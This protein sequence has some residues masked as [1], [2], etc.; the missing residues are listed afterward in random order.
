M[1][2]T[3]SFDTIWALY[4]RLSQL[5]LER[6]ISVHSSRVRQYLLYSP[7]MLASHKIPNLSLQLLLFKLVWIDC[8]SRIF[9]VF[10]HFQILLMIP[11]SKCI[12]C[13]M[14]YWIWRKYS[15]HARNI[16]LI[17]TWQ[18]FFIGKLLALVKSCMCRIIFLWWL[19]NRK[20]GSLFVHEIICMDWIGVICIYLANNIEGACNKIE[21]MRK[22][23][24]ITIHIIC[25]VYTFI[26]I[27]NANTHSNLLV[28]VKHFQRDKKNN[29]AA[30]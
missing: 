11:Q 29:A 14:S 19:I 10:P 23:N 28:H 1:K 12:S 30:L 4:T 3:N 17:F 25:F 24:T 20:R 8:I 6:K 2:Y 15:I 7:V 27:Y 16:R 5:I 9:V 13:S 22:R 18:V 21:K 26:S